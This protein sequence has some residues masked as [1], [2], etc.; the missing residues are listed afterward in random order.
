VKESEPFTQSFNTRI[1]RSGF[2]QWFPVSKNGAP[3]TPVWKQNMI[4]LLLL[5]P[6][7][8]LFGAFAQQPLLIDR[9]KMPFWL[10][11]FV[12]NVVSILLL[13][14]LVPFASNR[15]AWWLN[16]AGAEAQKK[17]LIGAGVMLALYAACLFAFSQ[18]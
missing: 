1:V 13:N 6:V 9:L 10:A 4:V 3:S 17:T 15:F 2:D 7:V 14:W 18:M 16:A 11:L 12:G 8:F 5:Y